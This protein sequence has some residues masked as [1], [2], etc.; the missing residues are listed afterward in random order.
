MH[1]RIFPD[2]HRLVLEFAIVQKLDN[3]LDQF[4]FDLG[5]ID[6]KMDQGI[7]ELAFVEGI[8][9]PSRGDR[10][11]QCVGAA[12]SDYVGPT[13]GE[14]DR[15]MHGGVREEVSHSA[16]QLDRKRDLSQAHPS[17]RL[18]EPVL[19]S[20]A[21]LKEPGRQQDRWHGITREQ[22]MRE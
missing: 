21:I 20:G 12:K 11:S 14:R 19:L 16:I 5:M 6:Q 2:D 1:L 4:E 9:Q 15:K 18:L 10:A 8:R 7:P 17:S 3:R 13:Q 22:V